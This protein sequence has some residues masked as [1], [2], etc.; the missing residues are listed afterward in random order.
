[1]FIKSVV[2]PHLVLAQP[3]YIIKHYTS[4]VHILVL[5]INLILLLLYVHA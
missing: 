2:G 3:I 1:M 5:I 4:V